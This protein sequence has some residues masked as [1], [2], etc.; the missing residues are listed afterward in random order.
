MIVHQNY[1]ESG[2]L[3][4]IGLLK[5]ESKIKFNNFTK[6]VKLPMKY[7]NTISYENCTGIAS[8]WGKISEKQDKSKNLLY[9]SLK[10]INNDVCEKYYKN[11]FHPSLL[12]TSTKGKRSIC[13][14]DSGG[15]FVLK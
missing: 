10:I 15:P 2:Y 9:V 12:C 14:G 8:G 3:Y 11:P 6:A 7:E 4:D 1:N 5:L 13:T